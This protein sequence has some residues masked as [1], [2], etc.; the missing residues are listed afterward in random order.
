[1]AFSNPILFGDVLYQNHSYYI[2]VTGP[3]T[4]QQNQQNLVGLFDA[5][6]NAPA[7]TQAS[8]GACS[9]GLSSWDLGVRGDRVVGGVPNHASGFTLNPVYSFL[10]STTGYGT[11][12]SGASPGVIAQYCNGS[13][14][15]PECTA[16]DGCGGPHGFGT[17]PGIADAL[18]P[19]P[20]FSLVPNATVDEGNN[21]I[22]VSWGPLSL[23]NPA[24]RG[25]DGNYGGGPA[26]GNYGLASGS[27]AI[28]FIPCSN[29]GASM[30]TTVNLASAYGLPPGTVFNLNLP[31]SD[32]FG[33]QR[34][35]AVADP[36]GRPC[37]PNPGP[38]HPCVDVGAVET[39]QNGGP[40]PLA[41]PR[42][43][44]M[45]PSSTTHPATG[46]KTV[47]VT[48]L[49]SNLTGAVTVNITGFGVTAG[50]PTVN[51]GG[52]LLTVTFTVQ[53]TAITPPG[54]PDVVTVTTSVGTST[55]TLSFTVN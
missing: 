29:T 26:L 22:N 28:D 34:P 2:G 5:F 13:R 1:M 8:T 37:A 49:G 17:P 55:N 36:N 11:T 51:P 39:P 52:T 14:V 10:T 38:G 35:D 30:C 24:V 23:S 3:G 42:L 46:S 19:N 44:S 6:S 41:L 27:A 32:F 25:T 54:Q 4:G 48:I 12:N 7:P 31:T 21:W 18:T 47:P 43:T 40:P 50:T 20:R 16:A 33:N 45:T 53:S 9:T 15:P